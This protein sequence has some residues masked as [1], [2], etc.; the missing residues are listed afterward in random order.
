VLRS[1]LHR[2]VL[3]VLLVAAP[4]VLRA[5]VPG[6]DT[7]RLTVDEAVERAIDR[8]PTLARESLEIARAKGERLS[9]GAFFPELPELEYRQATD[10]PFAN[11]GEGTWEVGIAQEIELGGQPFL[12]RDAGDLGVNAAELRYRAAQIE[13]RSATREAYA[14]LA[15]A[16]ARLRLL[17][18]LAAFALRLDVAAGR[19]LAAEEISELDRNAI[20]IERGQ[21]EIERLSAQGDVAGARAELSSLLQTDASL[22]LTTAH[23]APDTADMRAMIERTI[24]VETA[25]AAGD[26]TVISA[27]PDWQ[28]LDMAYRR[29]EI[30]RRLASR[31]VIPNVRVGV[32]LESETRPVEH[33]DAG[34]LETARLLGFKLGIRLPLPLPGLYDRGE[35]E[36]AIAEA[37][38]G[39]AEA[40]QRL[41]VARIRSDVA[42]AIARM[43][44][45]AEALAMYTRDIAP[46][47]ARNLELLERGYRAGELSATELIAQQGQFVRAG[48]ALIEA[49]LEYAE[50]R[51]NFERALGR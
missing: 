39:I 4:L 43:R 51:A 48:E 20:R 16:E 14:R 1:S 34:A 3:L 13:V 31:R 26:T 29:A 33:G 2:F 38:M 44:P 21:T 49:Q 42:R 23:A 37:E 40:E 45:A 27:R 9:R 18:T 50:A 41:L 35:G 7:L 15:A 17:D 36:V 19:L 28:A 47:V 8:N 10:A 5:Q 12:R 11:E 30:E 24:A 32:S 25:I 46:L 6:V 22:V